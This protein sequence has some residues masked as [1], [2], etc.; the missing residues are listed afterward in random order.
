M[1]FLAFRPITLT[2]FD[3]PGDFL[4][5]SVLRWPQ[6]NTVISGLP[7]L[8]FHQTRSLNYTGTGQGLSKW[9]KINPS[10]GVYN[11]GELDTWVAAHDA[12]GRGISFTMH[13]CPSWVAATGIYENVN[14]SA[15]IDYG[16]GSCGPV[17][18][19]SL[20]AVATFVEALIN[21][22][23]FAA[24]GVFG[25]D[26]TRIK[27][28]QAG[29]EPLFVNGLN[30]TLNSGYTG[31]P[32]GTITDD[33][34]GHTATYSSFNSTTRVLGVTSVNGKFTKGGT[35][36]GSG[37]SGTIANSAFGLYYQS[38]F[39]TTEL[40]AYVRQ[41]RLGINA[42]D[43]NVKLIGPAL[44][45]PQV[46]DGTMA[47]LY[48][49]SDGNGGTILDHID[50][51]GY[52][53]YNFYSPF[54]KGYTSSLG[55]EL[56]LN[57]MKAAADIPI[58]ITETGVSQAIAQDTDGTL[59][60]RAMAL[61]LAHNVKLINVYSYDAGYFDWTNESLA[62]LQRLSSL[63]GKTVSKVLENSVTGEVHFRLAGGDEVII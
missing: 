42:A 39:S 27:S 41:C 23:N 21:R 3:V 17:A 19:A 56:L 40:A 9:A 52:N 53:A 49:A 34:T 28:I 55:I 32:S 6:S 14:S 61:A 12:A 16:A 10:D 38:G 63:A 51:H 2:S 47:T 60:V 35:V 43:P 37:F 11:W 45:Y 25:T 57:R 26:A 31:T 59:T 22:Y 30:I 7:D 36:S 33:T 24:G 5:V 8:T 44:G 15:V 58:A 29:N 54:Y 48:A 62:A 18:T 50:W 1:T 46:S 13:G 4:A 20:G